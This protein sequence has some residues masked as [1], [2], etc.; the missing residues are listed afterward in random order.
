MRADNQASKL[1][2]FDLQIGWNEGANLPL[3]KIGRLNDTI[4]LS[5]QTFLKRPFHKIR[6]CLLIA[7]KNP[8]GN[9]FLQ[10]LTRRRGPR[11]E[12]G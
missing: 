7:T 6:R 9:S 1:G 11:D 10:F 2:P 4:H 3:S 12:R 5:D 8:L